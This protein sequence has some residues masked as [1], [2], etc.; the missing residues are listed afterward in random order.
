MRL[1]TAGTWRPW[2][3]LRVAALVVVLSLSFGAPVPNARGHAL[4]VAS[5]P[6]AGARVLR[7]PAQIE[8][9]FSEPLERAFSS[10]AVYDAGG[11]SRDNRDVRVDAG[12]A[13]RLTVSLRALSNGVYTVVW[14]A[15]SAIDGHVEEGRYSFIV[16]GAGAAGQGAGRTQLAVVNP[17]EALARG[18]RHLALALCVGC[19]LAG[20]WRGD[21]VRRPDALR[22]VK[23]ALVIFWPAHL[24]LWGA[25]AG[26]ASSPSASWLAPWEPVARRW[27]IETE[28]GAAWLIEAIGGATLGLL[29]QSTSRRWGRWLVPVLALACVLL[30]VRT[31]WNGSWL[32]PISWPTFVVSVVILAGGVIAR[33]ALA[34]TPNNDAARPGQPGGGNPKYGVIGALVGCVLAAAGVVAGSSVAW[35]TLSTS[36]PGGTLGAT[37][38]L[39]IGAVAIVGWRPSQG[40]PTTRHRNGLAA[41]LGVLAF[42]SLGL[43]ASLPLPVTIQHEQVVDV[44]GTQARLTIRPARVGRNVFELALT[45]DGQPMSDAADVR[46]LIHDVGTATTRELQLAGVGVG[47]FRGQGG[48]L[49]TGGTWSIEAVAAS[50]AP[51]PVRVFAFSIELQPPPSRA[52]RFVSVNFGLLWIL[53][54][55][56]AGAVYVL[57]PRRSE[58]GLFG[59]SAQNVASGG[60][61]LALLMAM[62]APA[63]NWYVAP[64]PAAPSEPANPVASSVES[65]SRGQALFEAQCVPCHG[66]TGAGDGAVGRTLNP[67]PADL[68]LHAVQGVHTDGALYLWITQGIPGSP[69]PAFANVLNER[70]RW[71]IVNYVR[72]LAVAAADAP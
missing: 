49:A 35:N 68:R 30:E 45:R 71:D 61:A 50:A 43:L 23:W 56:L 62:A 53:I 51:G 6:D 16:G 46:L 52:T 22:L 7:A 34:S 4:L 36:A 47:L 12:D 39:V 66:L 27:L 42:L 21:A 72:T 65:V 67:T 1:R 25:A 44:D 33:T 15:V 28:P 64:R 18:L 37:L 32:L 31:A 41:G 20:A 63:W 13:T 57:W 2:R 24:T 38:L 17:I 29:L 40:W 26:A 54:A 14:H 3:S 11:A 8:M 48:Q 70:D 69:M 55:L 9:I 59:L 60:V 58:A 19:G 10:V 5:R